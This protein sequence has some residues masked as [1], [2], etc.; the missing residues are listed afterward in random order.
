MYEVSVSRS[1]V[2]QH[3]LTVAEAGP[4]G[5]LHSH[6]YTVTA[7]FAG[8][9][10]GEHG[11]L[12]DIDDLND[13]VDAAVGRFRDQSLNKLESFDGHNP[14]VEHFSRIFGDRLLES[15]EP[16]TATRLRISMAEDDIATVRHERALK[17]GTDS[18]P[19]DHEA[20]RHMR[21]Q[22]PMASDRS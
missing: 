6:Q 19:T 2:A 12:V 9:T 8:P 13:A 11:Y 1:F 15:L 18:V 10:L 22:T 4:E 7:T 20:E 17:S 5:T 16:P 21:E 3:A 14:S